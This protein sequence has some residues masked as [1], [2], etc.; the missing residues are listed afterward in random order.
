MSAIAWTAIVLASLYWLYAGWSMMRHDHYCGHFN[1][2]ANKIVGYLILDWT[3][4]PIFFLFMF[5][6][7][8][9]DIRK[10]RNKARREPKLLRAVIAFF[11]GDLRGFRR[12]TRQQ[13][14]ERSRARTAELEKEL[15]YES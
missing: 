2:P 5:S 15:G 3:F 10:H 11:V 12:R 6:E 7:V 13:E 8:H 14:L 1:E 9:S 4:G